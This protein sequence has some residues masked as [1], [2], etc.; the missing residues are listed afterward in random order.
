MI[1]LHAIEPGI[2][3]ARGRHWSVILSTRALWTTPALL[4]ALIVLSCIALCAGPTWLSCAE[5]YAALTGT[6]P[7]GLQL[8]VNELRLPRIVAGVLA[9]AALGC[10]GCLIQALSRNRLATPDMLGVSDGAALGIF[11]GL[12]AGGTGLMGPWWVGPLG[13]LGALALLALAA[14]RIG[15]SVLIVG[16][17]VASLLRALTELALSRQEL[18]HASALYTWSVGSLTGRGYAAALPLAAGLLLLLPLASMLSRRLALL[19]L[20][21]DLASALGVPLR[22]TQWQALFLAV[23]LSGLAVG[24]CGPIAFVA[25]AAPYIA[26]RLQGGIAPAASAVSGAMLVLAADALGRIVLDGAELPA[27]V[28]CNLLGGPFLLWLVLSERA[29]ESN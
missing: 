28:I 1:G 18:M 25:L 10:A 24:V 15:P 23:I 6:G 2:L 29:G 27:G 11:I 21:P 7:T 26:T 19:G 16:V 20:G 3:A 12:A 22:A 17:G 5:L 13:A 14:G 9:G 4:A 8:L